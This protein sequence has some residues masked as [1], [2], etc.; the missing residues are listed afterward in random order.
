MIVKMNTKDY[1]PV[2]ESL[3]G[4]CIT[5]HFTWDELLDSDALLA[6]NKAHGTE[7]RNLN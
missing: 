6:H 1:N 5:P 3:R 4:G 7:Y 2:P